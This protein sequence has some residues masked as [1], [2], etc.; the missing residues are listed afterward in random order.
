MAVQRVEWSSKGGGMSSRHQFE[1]RPI[2]VGPGVL[3]VILTASW[4]LLAQQA[5]SQPKVVGY[6][7]SWERYTLPASA[8]KFEY[9]THVN[10]AFAWPLADGSIAAYSD[11]LNPALV[12]GAHQAGRKV[13]VSL[14]GAGQCDGFAPMAKDSVN[15]AT[16]VRN[17]V[18]YMQTNGFD[19]ADLDWETPQNSA[20]RGAL[21]RLVQ[22]LRAAFTAENPEWLLTM[23]IPPMSWSAG[24]FDYM[25]MLPYLDWYNVMNYDTHG[26]WSAHAGHNCPLYSPAFDTEG[27]ID[28]SVKY[29]NGTRGI[30]RSKLVIGI[31]FYAKE[32]SADSLYR[33]STGC[34]DILYKVIPGR[35]AAGW[36]RHWDA[37][38]HVPYL[39]MPSAHRTVCYDDSLSVSDKCAYALANGLGGVMMWALGQDVIGAHQP[40]LEAIGKA[41]EGATEVGGETADAVPDAFRLEQ[42]FPNPFNPTTTIRFDLA[43]GGDVS[44]VVHDLLGRQ[45]AVLA[46]GYRDAGSYQ[47]TW[48]GHSSASGVYVYVLRTRA[49]STARRMLLMR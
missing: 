17:L 42:N 40:L 28:Q 46:E 49:F 30:P 10:Q 48:N 12:A 27:S 37:T 24:N 23:A 6:F 43:Q 41:M 8:M 11:L 18:G 15:R 1:R 33:P 47:V 22:D 44:L 31:P 13:L 32:F 16:F 7:P 36:R 5:A 21:L 45:V 2:G 39:T 19:G 14:G 3:A 29:L 38:S 4:C 34:T 35:I 20:E 9:L 26:S 25:G